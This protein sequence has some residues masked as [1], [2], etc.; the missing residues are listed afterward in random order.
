MKSVIYLDNN[1]T[2]P[3]D[4]RVLEAM[5]PYLTNNF[6]NANSTHQFG[7]EA[8]EVVKTARKQVADLI[9]AE[10][11]EIIFTSGSTE[12]INLAIK[13][14]AEN[15]S[16]KGKHIVTVKTEHHA[17]LDTCQYLETKGFE[18][19]YLPVGTDGLIDLQAL[20]TALRPDTILVSVMYVN[21]ET[22][23]IQPIKQIAQLTHEAGALFMTDAT[24]AVGKMTVNV[25]E[26]NIDLLCLSGHKFYAPKG[27]GALFVRQ[28][29]PNRVKLPALIHGGGHER[30]LRSGTLNVPGIIA[31]GKACELAV[32][33]M[34]TNADRIRELRDYLEA[35][36]LKIPGTSVNGNTDYR[37]Y[38]VTNL[39]FKGVDSEAMIMGLSEMENDL[40]L[41]AVSNG[42]ACTST[43]IEPSH[44]LT[45][46]GL[47]EFLAFNC[48]RFSL[49]KFNHREEL[50]VVIAEVSKTTDNLRALNFR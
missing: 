17:V 40:P 1:A 18:V 22:G 26:D 30:G 33:E 37:L 34:K 47:N 44:V 4:P 23:V 15:Y 2:T 50:E 21:N 6:A 31:L 35:E 39:C 42:S 16:D 5:M 19:T 49:G 46:M 14:V 32:K 45:A 36:L 28:R 3:I 25:N 27:I 24:Q 43:S 41:M 7:V 9:G 10:T 8:Y 29:R 38:N 48:I 13:G 20:K 11:N 12:A